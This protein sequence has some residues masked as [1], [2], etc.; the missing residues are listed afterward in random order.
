MQRHKF[1]SSKPQLASHLLQFRAA[2]TKNRL[3]DSCSQPPFLTSQLWIVGWG[4]F[5][6]PVFKVILSCAS[7]N[8][9]TFYAHWKK[10]FSKGL[11]VVMT[12]Q[13]Y[14]SMEMWFDYAW[15]LA[16]TVTPQRLVNY[17][18]WL[19]VTIWWLLQLQGRLLKWTSDIVNFLF[20][21][22]NNPWIFCEQVSKDE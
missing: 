8:C 11:N 12:V 18:W 7:S 4:G 1:F 2:A 19:M 6:V 3:A 15:V 17:C 21:L 16:T 22:K 14:F 20:D 5:E 13:S 10:K 9:H